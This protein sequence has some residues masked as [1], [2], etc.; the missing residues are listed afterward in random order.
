[1]YRS[2][3]ICLYNMY[4][5]AQT[6][7][8]PTENYLYWAVGPCAETTDDFFCVCPY[9]HE[10]KS[11]LVIPICNAKHICTLQFLFSLFS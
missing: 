8:K 3:Q 11:N 4:T 5:S 6:S 1:M 9:K 10:W 2:N 7:C